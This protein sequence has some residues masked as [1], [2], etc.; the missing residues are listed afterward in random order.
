MTDTPSTN[1]RQAETRALRVL[2]VHP[3]PAMQAGMRRVLESFTAEVPDPRERVSF[4]MEALDSL[5]VAMDRMAEAPPDILLVEARPTDDEGLRLPGELLARGDDMPIILITQSAS[6]QAAVDATKEGAFDFLLQPFT[7]AA[8]RHTV[9]RAARHVL[10]TRRARELEE[11]RKRV[12]FDFIRVL[13]HELKAPLGA[14]TTNI[15]LLTGRYLGDDLGSYDELMQRCQVRLEQMRKLIVD[16]LDMTRLESGQKVR[17]L[18]PVDL[19]E[20][21]RD[22]VELMTPQAG[23]RGIGLHIEAPDSC[24]FR[25]DRGEIDMILNNLVSNAVKYN[26]DNGRVTVTLVPAEGAVSIAV[27]DTGIG[28]SPEEVSKLFGEFVRIRNKKTANILG[29]GLGLSILKRLVD[30]YHGRIDVDSVPDEGTTFRVTLQE[31]KNEENP[32]QPGGEQTS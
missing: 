9:D 3:N 24:L 25:A 12:R 31:A 5:S 18:A 32:T 23:E 27:S 26:R 20:A 22:A 1:E 19:S 7:P 2:A 21:I 15:G 14:V 29:S 13:G 10:L 17:E 30:L 8:F 4:A 16:L 28:M 6:I 11:E